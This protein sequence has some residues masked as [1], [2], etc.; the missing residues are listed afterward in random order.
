MKK[1][2]ILIISIFLLANLIS[3]ACEENQIDINSAS[4][5]ELDEIYGIGPAKAQ[6]IVDARPYET[7]DDLVNAY[8]IGEKTLENI[9]SQGLACVK[10]S[11]EEKETS[12]KEKIEKVE[13]INIIEE[14]NFNEDLSFVEFEPIKLNSKSIKTDNAK[15]S[16][17]NKDKQNSEIKLFI[18]FCGLLVLLFSIKIVKNKF[19][20]K[21][22]FG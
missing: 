1:L 5:E 16:Q 2:L 18:V 4:L 22:E 19:K 13:K 17:D 8:G 14:Y 6:A 15:E 12:E 11:E 7:L 10:G 9:K 3:A 20:Y 21:N